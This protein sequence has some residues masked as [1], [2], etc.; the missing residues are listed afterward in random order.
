MSRAML[1]PNDPEVPEGD[2]SRLTIDVVFDINWERD[3][4][5]LVGVVVVC[6]ECARAV[7]GPRHGQ[8]S[9]ENLGEALKEHARGHLPIL[10]HRPREPQP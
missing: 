6:R 8:P 4:Y 3:G 5:D 1:D 7:A 2:V 9:D 10:R